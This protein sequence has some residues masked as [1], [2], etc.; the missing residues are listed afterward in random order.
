MLILL[1]LG[2]SMLF[3]GIVYSDSKLYIHLTRYFLGISHNPPAGWLS[4]RPLIPL[5]TVP[6][7]SGLYIPIAYGVVNSLFW[8]GSAILTYSI[9]THITRRRYAALGSAVLL[10]S[11][12][13]TLLYFGS[14]MLEGGSTFFTL[15]IIW[16]FLRYS[17]KPRTILL[18]LIAGFGLLSKESTLP[19]VASILLLGII[20]KQPKK[21]LRYV[22]LLVLPALFW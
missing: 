5:L 9:T 19:A 22:I 20:D 11:S 12:P 17:D 18:P 6:L 3:F 16:I 8:I 2:L 10:S 7:A 21:I 13:P 4:S 15:L 1:C 14:V